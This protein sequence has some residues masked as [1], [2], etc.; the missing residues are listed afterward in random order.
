MVRVRSAAVAMVAMFAA[1]LGTAGPAA[2]SPTTGGTAAATANSPF[3]V[4][5]WPLNCAAAAITGTVRWDAGRLDATIRNN[6]YDSVT[7]FFS[8]PG[9]IAMQGRGSRTVTLTIPASTTSVAV[10]L[11]VPPTLMPNPC[12]SVT[13]NRPA[14]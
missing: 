5:A 3:Q 8:P 10:R 9:S 2:A 13:V 14:A 7:A 6:S 11:C 4:C 12:T 1:G